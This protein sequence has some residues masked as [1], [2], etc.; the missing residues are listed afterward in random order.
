MIKMQTLPFDSPEEEARAAALLESDRTTGLGRHQA[1]IQDR[2]D[3]ERWHVRRERVT[4]T[5]VSFA[6]GGVPAAPGVGSAQ[7]SKTFRTERAAQRE[8]DA[9]NGAGNFAKHGP[10]DWTAEVKPGRAPRQAE[11]EAGS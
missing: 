7:Y 6:Q 10:T 3:A 4:D 1:A 11:A 5:S 2:R 8:A 9:W